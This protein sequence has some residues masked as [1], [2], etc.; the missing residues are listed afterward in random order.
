MRW[1]MIAAFVLLAG[2]NGYEGYSSTPYPDPVG[3]TTVCYGHR[4]LHGGIKRYDWQDCDILALA[5]QAQSAAAVYRCSRPATLG[6]FLAFNDL[7]YNIGRGAFCR[8]SVARLSRQGKVFKP[9][10]EL[11]KYVYARGRRMNGLVKRRAYDFHLC[12]HLLWP[13]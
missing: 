3:V 2:C 12:T 11:K 5:D 8:S 10:R 7:A 1:L 9:C 4:I 13:G 6:Q